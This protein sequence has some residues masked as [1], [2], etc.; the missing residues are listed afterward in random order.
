MKVTIEAESQE[1]FDLKRS[2]LIKILSGDIEKSERPTSGV[3]AQDEMLDHYIKKF[4]Q[5][6]SNIKSDIEK[7][8]K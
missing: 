6:I 3:K 7:V 4:D 2:D 5:T 8:L 1:E